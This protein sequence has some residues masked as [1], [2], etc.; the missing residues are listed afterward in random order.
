MIKFALSTLKVLGYTLGSPLF[1]LFIAGVMAWVGLLVLMYGWND[2]SN[3][4]RKYRFER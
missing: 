2:Q 1:V 4:S 3:P